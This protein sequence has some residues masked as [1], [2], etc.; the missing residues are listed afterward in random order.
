MKTRLAVLGLLLIAAAPAAAQQTVRERVAASATGVV[1]IH[2]IG[3]SIRVEGVR[4]NAV[5]VA[6]SISPDAARVDVTRSGDRTIVK[7]RLPTGRH[8]HAKADLVVRVPRGSRVEVRTVMAPIEVRGVEGAMALK[9][10]QGDIRVENVRGRLMAES[11]TGDIHVLGAADSVAAKTMSGRLVVEG[12][13]GVLALSSVSGGV[14]VADARQSAGEIRSVSGTIEF[15]GG[16]GS[17]KR[18][19]VA[20]VSGTTRLLLDPAAAATFQVRSFSGDIQND[21][22]HEA[23]RVSK[24]TSA[25]ELRFTTGRT[26][27]ATLVIESMSGDVVIKRQ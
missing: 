20:N 16:F 26:A 5:E 10:V 18:L 19:Q 6:G 9:S 1:E 12:S 4:G 7:F 23:V 21:F 15:A 14:R 22:G 24:Y 27:G 17:G 25:R 3:G 13:R 2:T 11:V 8:Q